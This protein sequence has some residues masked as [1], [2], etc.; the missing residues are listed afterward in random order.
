MTDFRFGQSTDVGNTRQ[1][2]QDR[3]FGDGSVFA[4]ADG[5]GG[6]IGGEVA[7][8]LT[9]EALSNRLQIGTLGDLVT[10]VHQ[11]NDRIVETARD[12]PSLRGMGTTISMLAALDEADGE[13]R[14]GIVNVG[15]SRV[16]RLCDGEILQLTEDHSLVEAL[17][18][19]G[20]ITSEEAARHPQRNILTRALG[21]DAKVLVDAWEIRA[22]TGDRYLICSDGLFNELT[23]DQIS[24]VVAEF[25]DPQVAAETLVERACDAGGRDNVTAV[26]VQVMSG[27]EISS[28]DQRLVTVRRGVPDTK[29]VPITEPVPVIAPEIDDAAEEAVGIDS[30]ETAG[31]AGVRRRR[32]RIFGWRSGLLTTGLVIVLVLIMAA[33]ASYA[34]SGYFVAVEGSDVVIFQGR[35]GGMMWFDPTVEETVNVSLAE[36]EGLAGAERAEMDELEFGSIGDARDYGRKLALRIRDPS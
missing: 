14:L 15:D 21:I 20:R 27:A 10:L 7:S 3:Y 26:I 5:M 19:D 18:R 28:E 32:W 16:Y 24:E 29:P 30:D 33:V 1:V 31:A 6:H 9:V 23:A 25:D 2:N 4:V 17:V 12:D 36:L 34:R 11:A 35:R 22:V 13:G 8:G